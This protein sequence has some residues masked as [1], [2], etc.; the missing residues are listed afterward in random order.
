MSVCDEC[1]LGE[2]LLGE[3]TGT[4]VTIN[5]RREFVKATQTLHVNGLLGW[6][7][8]SSVQDVPCIRLCITSSSVMVVVYPNNGHS[9][10]SC[11]TAKRI[12]FT[13]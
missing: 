10:R 7:A 11:P 2:H 4:Q 6:L 5:F 12:T 3:H 9:L 1:R 8:R 13:R